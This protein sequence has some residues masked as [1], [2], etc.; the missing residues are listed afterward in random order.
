MISWCLSDFSHDE[1]SAMG[2]VDQT[3]SWRAF[4]D[5]AVLV[6]AHPAGVQAFLTGWSALGEALGFSQGA[7]LWMKLPFLI[8]SIWG[9]GAMVVAVRRFSG[10]CSRSLP[11]LMHPA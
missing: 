11:V 4:W 6:D 7:P 3:D 5:Q 9:L 10:H 2:R 8:V 1:F